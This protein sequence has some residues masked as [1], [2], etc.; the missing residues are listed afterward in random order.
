MQIGILSKRGDRFLLSRDLRPSRDPQQVQKGLFWFRTPEDMVT[1]M[2][3]NGNAGHPA[4]S[5]IKLRKMEVY[6]A[7]PAPGRAE[8]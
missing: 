7:V 5:R 3:A 2:V 1:L 8:R 4:V 6:E